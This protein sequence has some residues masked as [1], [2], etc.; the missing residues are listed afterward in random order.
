[1]ETLSVE[2]LAAVTET[3]IMTREA[4]E[5]CNILRKLIAGLVG[6]I[7]PWADTHIFVDG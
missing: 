7:A 1:M 3:C 2:I 5:I 4:L 6:M